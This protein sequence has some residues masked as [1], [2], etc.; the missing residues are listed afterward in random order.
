MNLIY[1]QHIFKSRI[2]NTSALHITDKY[3]SVKCMFVQVAV[4]H[5]DV[6]YLS[7][8]EVRDLKVTDKRDYESGDRVCSLSNCWLSTWG[9]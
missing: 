6:K 4:L 3:C 8:I 7:W 1:D 5:L 2:G 9:E